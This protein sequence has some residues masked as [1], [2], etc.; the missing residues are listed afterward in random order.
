LRASGVGFF[1]LAGGS[2]GGTKKES[3]CD[4]MDK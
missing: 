2:V 3:S 4:P 1:K